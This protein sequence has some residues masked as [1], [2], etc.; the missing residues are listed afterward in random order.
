M[1]SEYTCQYIHNSGKI[2]SALCTRPE[3][4][5][6]HYPCSD[7]EKPT[8]SACER[9]KIHMRGYYVTS[10]YQ[11]L[12][13]KTYSIEN[14]HSIFTFDN[15][16][17]LTENRTN[18][19]TVLY[20][21]YY[22]EINVDSGNLFGNLVNNEENETIDDN[23]QKEEIEDDNEDKFRFDWMLLIKISPNAVINSSCDLGTQTYYHSVLVDC[24]VEA[25][26]IIILG[27]AGTGKSYRF[28]AY[29]VRWQEL[30]LVEALRIIILGTAG[31]GKSYRFDAY[32]V[33][34]QELSLDEKSMIECQMFTLIEAWLRQVFSEHRN[35]LFEGRL[36]IMVDPVFNNG[37]T[38]YKQF[39]KAYKLDI[40]QKQSEDSEEQW[41]FRDILLQLCN[42][43]FTF[44][45]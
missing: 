5:R 10:Y 36:V 39:L 27:T 4:C 37:H 11:R 29:L 13:E 31:T 24:Q 19:W 41:K 14:S 23:D 3:G 17:N 45:D 1:I 44:D 35:E 15:A 2:C 28:D 12:H 26:R 38:A 20:N 21:S 42:G 32:L 6:L 16:N 9:C 43:E 22:D 18:N 25:L 33:R 7:C 40:I 8:A 34:W 30:S